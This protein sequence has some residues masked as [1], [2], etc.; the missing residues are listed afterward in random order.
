MQSSNK[1]Q[2]LR[3]ELRK[4]NCHLPASTYIPLVTSPA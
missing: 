2:T 4:L 3:E 1:E